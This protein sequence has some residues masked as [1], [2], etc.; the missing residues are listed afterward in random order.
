MTADELQAHLAALVRLENVGVFLGSGASAGPLGGLTMAELWGDFVKRYPTSLAWL[1]SQ[2]F[3][4]TGPNPNVEDLADNLEIAVREWKRQKRTRK[5]TQL[6]RVIA[7]LHR[8]IIRAALLREAWWKDPTVIDPDEPTLRSHRSL[9]HKL[10]AARQPGHPSPW[11]FT[12][13]YDLAVEWAAESI[14]LKVSNGFD[15]LHTRS[16]APHNFDLG[17]RNTL[18]RGEARFGTYNIYLAKLH[19]SLSWRAST[20]DGSYLEH[21]A[22]SLWPEMEGFLNGAST[23]TFRGP[24]VFPSAAKYVQTVGFVLGEL[25]RRFTDVLSRPQTCLLI[26]GYS[27]SDL[28]I[29]R[30]MATALQ[31]PT[32]Q[33]VIYVPAVIMTGGNL[34]A[35]AC[36]SWVQRMVTLESPQ[37]TIVGGGPAAYFEQFVTDLPDPAI[38]DEQAA[39]I[40]Q[41][42]RDYRAPMS[43][44][45]P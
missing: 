27:F 12:T 18:A 37:V 26:C 32:L 29:N 9:L 42:I 5:I 31:N 30:I 39:R 23:G 7:D 33:V 24:I 38:Y 41:M 40:R 4:P 6:Q 21:A 8:A 11:V 36:E 1:S 22:S 34:D 14:G 35:T 10:T 44:I 17:Y 2:G 45:A 15:G 28:H 16:F 20:G 25:L 13:N 43:G 19:G 3:L